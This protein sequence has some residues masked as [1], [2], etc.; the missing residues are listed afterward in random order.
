MTPENETETVTDE[1]F[2]TAEKE[3]EALLAGLAASEDSSPERIENIMRR[4]KLEPVLRESADFVEEALPKG[5]KGLA[6]TL[7]R[8]AGRDKEPPKRSH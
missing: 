7:A 2:A 4:I 3:I 5:L 1:E 8:L 6:D